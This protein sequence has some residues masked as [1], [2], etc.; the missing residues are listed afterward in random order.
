M[1]QLLDLTKSLE[2]N[3]K[4]AGFEKIPV[5]AV[6]LMVDRSGSMGNEFRNGFVQNTIDLFLAAAM[7]FDDDGVMQIGFFNNRWQET[8]E[9]TAADAGTYVKDIG[10]YADGGTCFAD[11]VKAFK[12]KSSNGLMNRLFNGGKQQTPVYI[13]LLTDGQ[14]HDAAEFEAQLVGMENTFVQIVAIGNG[15]STNYLNGVARKYKNVSVI[16]LPKPNEVKHDDFYAK[17]VHEELK[18]FANK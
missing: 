13:A 18:A 1:A 16:Y 10:M 3:L 2:L 7:K 12:G 6:K 14:C 15:V 5:M 17:L 4:K 11:G 9:V 8:R